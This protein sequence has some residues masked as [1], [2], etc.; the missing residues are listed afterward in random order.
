MKKLKILG[1]VA[2]SA[3]VT[4]FVLFAA[5]TSS[6]G[7]IDVQNRIRIEYD[8]NIYETKTDKVDSFKITEEIDLGVTLDFE[9]TFITLRY[10]PSFTWWDKRETDDTDVHHDV[11]VVLNHDFSPRVSFGIKNVYRLAD[12]PNEIINGAVVKENGQY[13]YNVTDANLDVQV[14]P[15]THAVIGGRYTVLR[16]DRDIVAGR[17]DYDIWAAGL[18]LRH[19]VSAGTKATVDF[20]HEDVEYDV[21]M[22]S[23]DSQYVGLGLEQAI[24]SKFVGSVRGG[25]QNKNFEDD[26]IDDNSSPY[27]DVTITY[28]HSPR[29]RASVGA[30]YSMFEA[31]VYPFA[32]Q[33]RTVVY[34]SMAHDLTAKVSVYLSGSYQLS[35]YDQSEAV[36][37]GVTLPKGYKGDEEVAQGGARLAYRVNAH[38]TIEL[39]YQHLDLSSDIRP[40]FDRNRASIG[41]RLDI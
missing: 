23:S 33:D 7:V 39:N 40:E 14:L 37:V 17:E 4:Q 41:W 9:P 26:T 8:D 21:T 19:A 18:T 20:R 15:R 10:R 30:G 32:N 2:V 34:A 6:S 25:Y 35:E 13:V 5:E 12:E 38:N 36:D 16:Y 3:I 22:R 29:T 1:V 31:D 27:G 24:G 28:I 11:D